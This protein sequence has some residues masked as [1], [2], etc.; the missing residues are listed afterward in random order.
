[1]GAKESGQRDAGHFTHDSAF[2]PIEASPE[3]PL[4]ALAESFQEKLERPFGF[5]L[6]VHHLATEWNRIGGF[7]VF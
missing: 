1:M 5:V 4:S 3:D 7:R 6:K 2:F